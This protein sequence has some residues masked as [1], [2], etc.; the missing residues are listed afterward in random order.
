M[1]A[2]AQDTK[3]E[4]VRIFLA[5]FREQGLGPAGVRLGVDGSTVSRRLVALEESLGARLFD[6]TREG[7]LPTRAA[8]LLLPSAEAMEAAHGQFT[9]EVS[10]FER[11]AEGTVR[12]SVAPGVADTFVAPSLVRLRARHPKIRIALDASIRPV[13]ISRREADIALRSVPPQGSDL[14]ISKLTVSRW[15]AATSPE[16]AAEVGRVSAWSDVPWIGWDAD[17]A[18][19]PAAQWVTRHVGEEA[20]A[21]R[22]SHFGAQ[23]AAAEAGLGTLLVPEPFLRLRNLV[24]LRHGRTL[25][26]SSE[27]WPSDTL[28]IVGHRALRDVPRIAAVWAFLLEEIGEWSGKGRMRRR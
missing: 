22:T 1:V 26:P 16:L 4:D 11:E 6:R 13:D 18:G 7:L 12:L 3:W 15:V 24:P 14:L 20:V 19:L 25:A 28:W 17:L 5:A 2:S 21:F 10:G 8:E 9:R 23:M 27:E